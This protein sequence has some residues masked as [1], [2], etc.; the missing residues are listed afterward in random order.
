MGVSISCIKSRGH[1]WEIVSI[2]R[3]NS[4]EG[5]HNNQVEW[6]RQN[7]G[8]LWWGVSGNNQTHVKYTW[9]SGGEVEL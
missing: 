5:S 8:Y 9:S 6:K 4:R 2:M 1:L 7:K 3:S